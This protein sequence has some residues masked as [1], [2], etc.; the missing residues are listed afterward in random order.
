M[1][2]AILIFLVLAAG[3]LPAPADRDHVL[4]R[5]DFDEETVETGPYTLMVFEH[6]AGT[7]E[8][9]ETYRYSGYR[10][11]E[12]R[13][14]AGDGDFTELQGYFADRT[15]G[16]LFLRFALMAAEPAERF[17]VAFAGPAHFHQEVKHGLGVWLRA[18]DGVMHHRT[19]G[20]DRPLFEVDA[21]TWYVFD[22]SYD[23]D[24]GTYDLTV[25]GEGREEPLVELFDQPNA[26]GTP[27]SM[28]HKFS[29]IGDVP[30]RDESNAHFFVDDIT[31]S[32]DRPV[33]QRPF[34]APGRRMLFVDMWDHYRRRTYKKPGCPPVLG[35]DDF[36]L[37]ARDLQG[38]DRAGLL[39][40]VNALIDGKAKPD[41]IDEP[42]GVNER[43]LAGI[44]L[45]RQ[46]CRKTSRCD[47]A[48]REA[49]LARAEEWLPGTK[50]LPMCRVMAL[51]EKGDWAAADELFVSVYPDWHDDPR[52][53]S[54]AAVLGLARGRIDD[55]EYE[56]AAVPEEVATEQAG[57][58]LRRLWSGDLDRS[59]VEALKQSHPDSW[60]VQLATA[61]AAEHRFY[62]LLWQGRHDEAALYAGR[63]ST[64]M[65]ELGLSPG[66]WIERRGDASFYA[67]DY[68]IALE[69]YRAALP[70]LRHPSSALL[71]LSD[72]HFKLGNLEEER[73]YREKIYGT[74]EPR[75]THRD[76]EPGVSFEP[77]QLC[78]DTD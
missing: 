9:S 69:S 44:E 35:H 22:L 49:S 19:A 78:S 47:V 4:V 13:D 77:C 23:I 46:G 33:R 61:L 65:M 64:R 15:A 18:L 31:V 76:P 75:W 59:L 2:A 16:K 20:E 7:V 58:A 72:V 63:M 71:K 21:F 26:T 5:Y 27:G 73:A 42:V 60:S 45:W 36:G 41:P 34:V 24:A 8:L 52:F 14:V 29:F 6:S 70:A 1:R 37:T 66:R 12:I 25:R 3:V 50:L 11:V 43:I 54:I 67:G 57:V 40:R 28:I 53:P 74:L 10:S 30:W 39:A 51:A 55:A 56:L 48:C 32:A 17:N 62:V 68:V 38:L